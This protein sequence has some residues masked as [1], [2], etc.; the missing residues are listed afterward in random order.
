MHVFE[1]QSHDCHFGVYVCELYDSGAI[2]YVF[3]RIFLVFG[4][5]D[6]YGLTD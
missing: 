3:C 1:C 4:V 6:E 5:I 2:V